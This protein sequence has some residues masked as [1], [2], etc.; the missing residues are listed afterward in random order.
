[1]KCL[2]DHR[3]QQFIDGESGPGEAAEVEQHLSAC[4][5]CARRAGEQRTLS[6]NIKDIM[7]HL[8]GE[9]SEIPPF[10]IHPAHRM[11]RYLTRGSVAMIAAAAV[12]LLLVMVI[13]WRAGD[14]TDIL[15]QKGNDK[16]TLD[17]NSPVTELPLVITVVD[18]KG[19]RSEYY[20]K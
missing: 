6:G 1:M 5:A 15:L 16:T 14:N 10:S 11:R 17:A 4:P 2:E 8:A 9:P 3:I 19:N 7:N 18:A 12:I 20:I 13:P